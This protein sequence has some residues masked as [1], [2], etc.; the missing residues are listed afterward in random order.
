MNA[1]L[2]EVKDGDTFQVSWTH[3]SSNGGSPLKGFKIMKSYL[4]SPNKWIEITEKLLPP[5]TSSYILPNAVKEEPFTLIIAAENEEN[6]MGPFSAP[7]N[8]IKP[9]KVLTVPDAP[10]NLRIEAVSEKLL[11][12]KWNEPKFDG[13][14]PIENYILQLNEDNND[15]WTNATSDTIYQPKFNWKHQSTK[16][17]N[18]RF[19]VAAI[20]K[21][22]I[23]E[24]CNLDSPFSMGK[25]SGKTNNL[26]G[27]IIS[28]FCRNEQTRFYETLGRYDDPCEG[29][30][31]IIV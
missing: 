29:N 24:Y 4:S 14:S 13:G 11:T 23:S 9:S 25:H 12:L 6:L 28:G 3:P 30:D 26:L 10:T 17:D 7:S 20:N 27:V 8:V 15:E 19:R 31:D 22:G 21:V 16:S 1:P 5:N 2:I 18:I